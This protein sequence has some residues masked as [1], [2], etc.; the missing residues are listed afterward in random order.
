MLPSLY[1][2]IKISA[3]E[4]TFIAVGYSVLA[5]NSWYYLGYLVL[6][7]PYLLILSTPAD[8]HTKILPY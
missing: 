3:P 5:N 4:H 1:P 2:Q 7:I 6:F 8:E